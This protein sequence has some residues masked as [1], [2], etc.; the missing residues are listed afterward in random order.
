LSMAKILEFD[1]PNGSIL[2]RVPAPPGE[3][4]AVGRKEDVIE[5][6]NA[7]M[8]E[9]LGMV[10]GLAQAFSDAL[11]TSPVES[12]ELEFGVRFTGKGS[13]YVVETEALAAV[14]VKLAVRPA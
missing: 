4:A 7:S 9:V 1:G 11:G 2:I 12:A 8:S 14:K 6:V 13:L 5:K 10:A 3:V